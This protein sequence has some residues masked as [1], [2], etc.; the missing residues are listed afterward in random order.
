MASA[1]LITHE[2]VMNTP[3]TM[4]SF[5]HELNLENRRLKDELETL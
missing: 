1:K 2:V 5:V 3:W 4:L